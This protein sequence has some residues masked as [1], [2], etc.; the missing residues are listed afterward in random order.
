MKLGAHFMNYIQAANPAS[1]ALREMETLLQ[2]N[3]EELNRA[4]NLMKLFGTLSSF[5]V[6]KDDVRASLTLSPVQILRMLEMK[7]RFMALASGSTIT[8]TTEMEM[9][10]A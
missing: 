1:L 7:A 8:R 9:K 4:L 3:R 5:L 10:A 2:L 6:E